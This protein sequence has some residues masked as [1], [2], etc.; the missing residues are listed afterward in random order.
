MINNHQAAHIV[1]SDLFLPQLLLALPFL[2]VLMMYIFAAVFSG[3][4]HKRWPI[5][6]TVFWVL[7]VIFAIIA[8]AGP[9]ANQA[10]LD[11]RAHILGH[12]FLG[13]LAPLLM[14]LGA[15]IRLAL[16]T[17]S[18]SLARK[19]SRILRSWP[20]RIYTDPI[21]ASLLNIG[22]LWL[23]YTTD[24]Y[25]MMHESILLHFIVHMHVFL[26]G[27]LFTVSIIYIDPMPHRSPFLYRSIVLIVALA[28]HGILSKYI[29]ANPPASVPITQ[30][31]NGAMIMYYGGDA[32][33][34]MLIFVL[35][36]QWYKGTRPRAVVSESL[37]Y[38]ES[39]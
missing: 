24:L 12:L 21:V 19:L 3:R 39:R 28:S 20:S 4:R 5:Y 10:H 31:E 11:F 7:G 22:G 16:R 36:Y 35:C 37:Q 1:S 13:M 32:I 18:T 38:H 23:L 14:A 26:A 17:F 29:Y 34:L 8:V 30:A 9:L 27:Y 25:S 2:A 15:P 6:R 33:D